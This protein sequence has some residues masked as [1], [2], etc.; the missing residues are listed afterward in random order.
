ME[1]IAFETDQI[2]WNE[3]SDPALHGKPFTFQNDPAT[4]LFVVARKLKDTH[5]RQPRAARSVQQGIYAD[6]NGRA[7]ASYAVRQLCPRR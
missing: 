3:V 2:Y 5:F 1:M 6:W 7:E 4:H